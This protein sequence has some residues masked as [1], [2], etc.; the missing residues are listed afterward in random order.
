MIF[1]KLVILIDKICKNI[2]KIFHL[3]FYVIYRW[4]KAY[5]KASHPYD[6]A[7]S[8][9]IFYLMMLNILFVLTYFSTPINE[10]IIVVWGVSSFILFVYTT[11]HINEERIETYK[12]EYE[13][14]N[15]YLRSGFKIIVFLY[16]MCTLYGFFLSLNPRYR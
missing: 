8:F 12:Q 15:P 2:C 14:L 6:S 16:I 5:L 13:S 10:L 7:A 4:F 1:R 9:F 3:Y 11:K